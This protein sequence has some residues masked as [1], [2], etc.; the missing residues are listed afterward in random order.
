MCLENLSQDLTI[1]LVLFHCGLLFSEALFVQVL[2]LFSNALSRLVFVIWPLESLVY[3]Y[4]IAVQ[5]HR[6]MLF[7][8]E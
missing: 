5:F 4:F 3:Y 6:A 2:R 1:C 8:R 7:L